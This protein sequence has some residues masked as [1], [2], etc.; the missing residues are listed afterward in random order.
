[1]LQGLVAQ[2]KRAEL[3]PEPKN[4]KEALEGPYKAQWQEAIEKEYGSLV[5]QKTWE[6]SELPPGRKAIGVRWLLK[7]KTNA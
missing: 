6:L 3:P 4:L 1:M 5:E 7:I 2:E